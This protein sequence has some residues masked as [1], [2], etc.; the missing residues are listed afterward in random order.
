MTAVLLRSVGAQTRMEITLTLRRGEN[1]LVT[2][3]VPVVLLVFITSSNV[4]PIQ[5]GAALDYLVPGILSLAIVS[6]GMVNLGIATAYERYYGVLK[7]LGGSPLPR[8]GL[9]LSKAISV[10]LLELVQ[11]L[12]IFTVATIG[13]GWQPRVMVVPALLAVALGSVTF[14]GLG[15]AMAGAF[16]A[17][18][19]LALANGLYLVLLLLGNI[20]VPTS[21]LPPILQPISLL[22]PATALSDYLRFSLGGAPNIPLLSLIALPAWTGGSVAAAMAAFRWE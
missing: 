19:T 12:L 13:L 20:L 8:G 14:C 11:V 6:T 2:L 16:R 5:G 17:E 3:I 15:L 9:L 18:A 4:M 22:L 7:R 1:I 10:M 21:H